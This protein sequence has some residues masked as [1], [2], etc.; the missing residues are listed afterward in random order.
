MA[1]M[2]HDGLG[3]GLPVVNGGAREFLQA[4]WS[5]LLEDRKRPWPEACKVISQ[6]SGWAVRLF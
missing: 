1:A 5:N 4:R 2:V 3:K 6:A